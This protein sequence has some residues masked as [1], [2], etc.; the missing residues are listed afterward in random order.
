MSLPP[1]A[2]P[3]DLIEFVYADILP[4]TRACVEVPDDD[5]IQRLAS[6]C[7]LTPRND[8]ATQLNEAVLAKFPAGT[9]VELQ[10]TTK[11]SGATAEDLASYPAEHLQYLDVP[12]LP[13]S[14]LRL[15]PG[16]LVMLLRNLD[17]E[18]GLCNG[19]RCLV[20]AMSPR[21][22]DVL[23]LTGTG[24]G[25]RAFLPRIPMSPAELT[26]PVKIVRRQFPV[27]LAWATTINK[28]QGQ[29]LSRPNLG[30]LLY[31]VVCGVPM[32]RVST[33]GSGCGLYLPLPVFAHGQLYV[34]LSRVGGSNHIRVLADNCSGQGHHEGQLFTHNVVYR[35]VLSV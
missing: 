14:T 4:S 17:Y 16:A 24:R 18:D 20:I 6:R 28:A 31:S 26:L 5:N 34:A 12:G 9:V 3:E 13:P 10:G 2:R 33:R 7:I 35:E 22:L 23:V 29:S 32:L 11:L 19:T 30:W 25:K 15:C 27:R 21:A 8:C 1:V